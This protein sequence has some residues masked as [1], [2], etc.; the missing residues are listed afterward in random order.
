MKEMQYSLSVDIQ[1]ESLFQ[2]IQEQQQCS[3]RVCVSN[4][5]TLRGIMKQ[6]MLG[7]DLWPLFLCLQLLWQ[8][9]EGKCTKDNYVINVMQLNHSDL[10]WTFDKIK[11]AVE[12][13]LRMVEK[14]LQ[15]A[16]K[17]MMLW[18]V[19]TIRVSGSDFEP[20]PSISQCFYKLPLRAALGC[21][22]TT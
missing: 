20:W 22:V 12:L 19:L 2:P 7:P 4:G 21:P 18:V 16:G 3:A 13:G 5:T 17:G 1:R 11:P 14:K 15:L 9:G 8:V 6:R 10:P